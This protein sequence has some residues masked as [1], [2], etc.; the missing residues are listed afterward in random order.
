MRLDV[1]IKHKCSPEYE[2]HLD[3][4]FEGTVE[5]SGI[6]IL[7]NEEKHKEMCNGSSFSRLIFIT[8]DL[9]IKR[10]LTCDS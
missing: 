5:Y 3:S 2:L 1:I 10:S 6:E 7:T 8:N 4:S 9:V